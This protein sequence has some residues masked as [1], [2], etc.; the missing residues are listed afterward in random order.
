M[1]I[2]F[3]D[4]DVDACA[5]AHTDK[6]VV[7]MILEYGQLL[8]SVH[9]ELKLETAPLVYK[10]THRNHPCAVWARSSTGNYWWLF[11]LFCAVHRE[12]HY[13]YKRVHTTYAKL[14]APLG[15]GVTV[16]GNPMASN[17]NFIEPPLCMPDE[18]KTGRAIESYRNYYRVGKAHLHKWTGRNPPDWI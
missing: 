11:D 4:Y 3:L 18:F 17:E 9:H 10:L 5:R 14:L 15:R 6:H 8:S 1:N 12:Y 13:R 7:K 2:F 16:V